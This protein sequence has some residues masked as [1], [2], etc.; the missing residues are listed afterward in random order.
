ME[1]SIAE[2]CEKGVTAKTTGHEKFG[3]TVE[4]ACCVDGTKLLPTLSTF[5]RNPMPKDPFPSAVIVQMNVKGS[6]DK[7]MT[8]VWVY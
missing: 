5:R 7:N 8:S 4:L 1:R 6:M 2:K 3:F